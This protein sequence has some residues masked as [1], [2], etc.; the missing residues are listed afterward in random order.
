MSPNGLISLRH[1]G[2]AWPAASPD[3][4]DIVAGNQRS[5]VQDAAVARLDRTGRKHRLDN[6]LDLPG[7]DL[8]PIDALLARSENVLAKARDCAG[9]S[10]S[11]L[12]R[13]A[14][15]LAFN[16]GLKTICVERRSHRNFETRL[17][18]S[19]DGLMAGIERGF[20]E[21]D[22]LMLARQM[23]ERRLTDR[24]AS[25]NLPALIEL[26]MARPLVPAG[27]LVAELDIT[28][29]AALHLVEELNLRE[30][31]GR[32]GCRGRENVLYT[33]GRSRFPTQSAFRKTV[34]LSRESG[35]LNSLS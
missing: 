23:M 13:Q 28:P 12:T 10:K 6:G 8:D 14:H 3:D 2:Q 35:R 1:A 34:S 17:V 25:S 5:T 32:N 30:M 27:L 26:V 18:A 29:R 33:C 9:L 21:Y 16:G 24:R 31:T 20:K 4:G 7:T 19:L 22:P 15:L 11:M